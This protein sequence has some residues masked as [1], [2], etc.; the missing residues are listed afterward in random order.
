MPKEINLLLPRLNET[1]IRVKTNKFGDITY[2]K[3]KLVMP[4][5]AIEGVCA[6]LEQVKIVL[7]KEKKKRASPTAQENEEKCQRLTV[8]LLNDKIKTLTEYIHAFQI[9]REHI[10]RRNL[11]YE[12]TISNCYVVNQDNLRIES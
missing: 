3:Y 12:L 6:M 2:M 4:C 8:L 9:D 11:E 7:L 10:H 1:L 5:V